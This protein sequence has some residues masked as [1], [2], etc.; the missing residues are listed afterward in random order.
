MNL[1]TEDMQNRSN[2]SREEI[3]R[4]LTTND[5]QVKHVIE[6]KSLDNPFDEDALEGWSDTQMKNVSMKR[7]DRKFG[8]SSNWAFWTLSML[9]VVVI[10][11]GIYIYSIKSPDQPLAKSTPVANS[12]TY[13][14]TDIVLPEQIETMEELPTKQQIQAKT[15]QKDFT[16]QQKEQEQKPNAPVQI[17]QLP[18]KPIDQPE[19]KTQIDREL[20]FGKEIYLRDLKIVDYRAYRSRPSITTKQITLTGTPANV[21]EN[22]SQ[23]LEQPVWKEVDVAYIDYLDKTMEMF[24]KGQNKKALT[25]FLV[26]LETYP[27]DLNAHFYAGLCYYNLK[28][29]SSAFD[30]FEK[31]LDSKYA[32][33][34]EEAEWYMAKS[35]IAKGDRQAAEKILRQ[36]IDAKGYYAKQ[37]EK[38]LK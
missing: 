6:K 15:I 5:E 12:V 33:F 38:L 23:E 18:V 34:N 22:E 20:I 21:G 4:Y 10:S 16:A 26:I 17:D 13:E 9:I 28:E 36:I 25:R 19:E 7:L 2:L 3:E 8:S 14:K 37:A 31:C 32:N 29:Y 11:A 30:S 1:N 24:M 35:L 27:D